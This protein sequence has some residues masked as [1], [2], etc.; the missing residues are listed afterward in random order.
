MKAMMAAFAAMAV[1]AVGAWYTLT[2]LGFDS[3][4]TN[5]GAGVRLDDKGG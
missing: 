1:I 2:H 3:G 4:S 5:A